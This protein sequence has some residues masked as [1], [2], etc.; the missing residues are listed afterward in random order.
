MIV[1]IISD[2]H[3][4]IRESVI[5]NLKNCSLIIHA[6]DIGNIKI[7]DEL[8]KISKVICIRGNCDKDE[9]LKLISKNEIIDILGFKIYI[10][11]DIKDMKEEPSKFDLIIHGHSHKSSINIINN[12]I[13]INPGSVGPRRF[14][15]PIT[16]MKLN[17]TNKMITESNIEVIEIIS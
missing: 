5:E 16:M 2:T 14:K 7:I 9:D 15:L 1:G 12:V 3:G 8:E 13:Y 17:I 11:H 10:I 4:L 6:G